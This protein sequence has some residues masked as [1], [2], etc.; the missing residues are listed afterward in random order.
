MFRPDAGVRAERSWGP[1]AEEN[2][3]AACVEAGILRDGSGR[4]AV[5][6]SRRP[7]GAHIVYTRQGRE[8]FTQGVRAGEF[9]VDGWHGCPAS[10]ATTDHSR[11][12]NSG[13]SSVPKP[14]AQ[15]NTSGVSWHGTKVRPSASPYA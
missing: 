5:R 1:Q 6:H 4:V 8:A 10:R 3:G 14:R 12:Q 15:L 2:G 13:T 9:D 11:D 7:E